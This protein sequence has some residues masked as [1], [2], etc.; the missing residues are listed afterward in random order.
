MGGLIYEWLKEN[1]QRLLSKSDAETYAYMESEARKIAAGSDGVLASLGSE[2]FNINTIS[3]VRPGAFKFQQP[4]HPMNTT[5]A[6]FAHFIRAALENIAF[7]IRGNIDQIEEITQKKTDTL[8]VTGGM[9]KNVLF[10][11]ILSQVTG[12]TVIVT[13]IED[14]TAMGSI[15]CAAVGAGI[16]PSLEK[17]ASEIVHLKKE[18][19]PNEET[20]KTYDR[21]Y[22]TWREWYGKLAEM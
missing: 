14:G 6:T 15:L 12:K 9:S 13:K 10:A 2:I 20:V 17:A 4:V 18:I 5:P 7:A 8:H 22:E 1:V 16:Y 11:E 19:T 21:C 3:V